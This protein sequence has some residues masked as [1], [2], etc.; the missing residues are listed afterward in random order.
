MSVSDDILRALN[1]GGP[2]AIQQLYEATGHKKKTLQSKLY[3]LR[4]AGKVARSQD[5]VYEVLATSGQGDN[6]DEDIL[7]PSATDRPG[8]QSREAR[9]TPGPQAQA[10]PLRQPLS[11]DQ[12]K[13]R[14][15][16]Q[17]CDVKKALDTITETFFAGDPEDLEHLASVLDDARAYVSPLQR[18]LIVRYWARYIKRD[19]PP[20]LEE[21]LT[22][23][24]S[25]KGERSRPGSEFVEDIGWKVEKD[26]DGD[27]VPRPGGD[28]SYEKALKYAATM[29]ATRG[30][31]AEEDAGEE[32]EGGGGR[33]R[34][35]GGGRDPILTLLIERA[36][37]DKDSRDDEIRA[38]REELDREREARQEERFNRLEGMVSS[39]LSRNPVQE[40]MEMKQQVEA[41]E[42]P[43]QPP[44]VTDQ[45]PTVQLIKDQSDKLDK[46]MNRLVGILERAVLR[47]Q[48]EVIPEE[49]STPE[50]RD[51]RAERLLG[52][53]EQATR[54]RELRQELFGR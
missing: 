3:E 1:E 9:D 48:E 22:H 27:W 35:R 52:R 11:G 45:S 49:H 30:S 33:K 8:P 46:N 26:K 44:I 10:S 18:R 38:L 34:R 16:L 43:R 51:K 31:S 25:E 4:Q 29:N 32:E 42:G 17:D 15:L 5:G 53:M 2:M 39:A 19:V 28:L 6:E 14:A 40:Y 20:L 24:E 13:F 12:E 47:G 36:F 50:E 37:P 21:R 7:P 54:S 23:Q 41:I